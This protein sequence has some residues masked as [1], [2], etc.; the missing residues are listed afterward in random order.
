MVKKS[1]RGK[2]GKGKGA[3]STKHF[4]QTATGGKGS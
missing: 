3:I 1:A 2:T 4:R